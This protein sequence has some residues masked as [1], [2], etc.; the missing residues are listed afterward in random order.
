MGIPRRAARSRPGTE[1]RARCALRAI[2]LVESRASPPG[3]PTAWA[4]RPSLHHTTS[5]MASQMNHSQCA[6]R[7][8]NLG[9]RLAHKLSVRVNLKRSRSINAHSLGPRILN[10]GQTEMAPEVH[11]REHAKQLEGVQL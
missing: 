4:R 3:R 7:N 5:F 2:A 9:G 1:Y 10:F 6:R 11:H 8:R